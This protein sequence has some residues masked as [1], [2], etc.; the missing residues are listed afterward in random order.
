MNF[1]NNL[2]NNALWLFSGKAAGG[3]FSAIQNILIA[4]ALGVTNYGLLVLILAYVEIVNNLLDLRVWEFATKYIGSY[5]SKK[6]YDKTCSIIKLSYIIDISTGLFAFIIAVLFASLANDIFIKSPSATALITIYAL[7]LLIN[8]A[9]STSNAILRVFDNF[10]Q[11]AFISTAHNFFRLV[12]VV[13]VLMV[14]KDIKWILIAFI[15]S[16][17]FGFIV[18]IIIVHKALINNGL[19]NW[20][21]VRITL[22]KQQ[23]K[24]MLWF[25]VNTSLSGTLKAARDN[26]L[27]VLFLGYVIGK[28]AAGLYKIAKSVLKIVNRITNPVNEAI[29]P[30]LVK[31]YSADKFKDFLGL[32]KYATINLQKVTLPIIVIIIV[33]SEQILELV[34]GYE[35]APA[36]NTMRVI[37]VSAMLTQL[38]FWVNPA[39]LALGRPGLRTLILLLSTV[40]YICLIV[41]F[42]PKYSHLG[43]AFGLLGYAIVRLILSFMSIKH[44]IGIEKDRSNRD[45]ISS[46]EVNNSD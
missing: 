4:R 42:V 36:Y 11:I 40:C 17:L 25:L 34:F 6:E 28:E 39:L 7:S 14:Q 22:V 45:L 18:R 12:A 23:R 33:F 2:F 27:G 3:I 10:K 13:L 20:W 32:L 30:E 26:S 8:T 16:S 37:A 24:E 9:N 44:S 46:I 41:I 38:M 31:I 5:W 19:T 35:Y 21:K 15:L 1:K 29:Y 43:A